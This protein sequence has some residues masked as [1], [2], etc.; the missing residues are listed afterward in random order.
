[1]SRISNCLIFRIIVH[2]EMIFIPPLFIQ[3]IDLQL[4]KCNIHSKFISK[5]VKR[6]SNRFCN[7][8]Y[9]H[10]H[11]YSQSVYFEIY[12]LLSFEQF[13]FW[14]KYGDKKRN[15]YATTVLE[16]IYLRAHIYKEKGNII[17]IIHF[18][19]SSVVGR[20]L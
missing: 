12:S 4:Y 17:I 16:P 8:Y 9:I 10:S 14:Q 7:F 11:T 19:I 5:Y 18:S 1:M 20:I 15:N 3:H 13:F 6:S 2:F